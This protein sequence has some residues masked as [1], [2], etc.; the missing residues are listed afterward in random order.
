MNNVRS[1][2]GDAPQ[3]TLARRILDIGFRCLECG[4]CC[5]GRDHLVL[6]MPDEVRDLMARSGGTWDE[7]VEPYPEFL[8][9][10]DGT[11]YTLGWCVRRQGNACRFL[12]GNHCTVHGA[13]PRICRTYPFMLLDGHLELSDCPGIGAP[14]TLEEAHALASALVERALGEEAEEQMVARVLM[15]CRIPAGCRCVVDTKGIRVLDG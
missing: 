12:S 3:D 10:G 9:P 14:M 5:R 8:E 2:A 15:E 1:A 6:V 13:R 4:S 11:C 7:I